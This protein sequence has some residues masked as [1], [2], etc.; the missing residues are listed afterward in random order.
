MVKKI[1]FHA[2]ILASALLIFSTATEAQERRKISRKEVPAPIQQA[3]QK[4]FPG[5]SIKQAEIEEKDGKLI[6]HLAGKR[7][8]TEVELVYAMEIMLI[9]QQEDIAIN[10]LPAVIAAAI[11][12]AHPNATITE[13]EK[14]TKNGTL[15]GYEVEIKD[16]NENLELRITPDGKITERKI[17]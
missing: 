9:E 2:T 7:N 13:T 14:I 12:T 1:L 10:D 8:G 15:L 11:K 16:G 5:V 4:T 3:F 17:D 6:Y